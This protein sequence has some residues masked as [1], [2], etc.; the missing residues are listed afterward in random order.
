MTHQTLSR[1]EIST[2]NA[3]TAVPGAAAEIERYRQ[4]T[5]ADAELPAGLAVALSRRAFSRGQPLPPGGVMLGIDVAIGD[6]DARAGTEFR[7][8]TRERTDSAGRVIVTI[9]VELRSPAGSGRST[10]VA[11]VIRW[12]EEVPSDA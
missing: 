7:C 4:L 2:E 12:P 1:A 9:D 6:W 5:G 8:G 10:T 11:F 3:W